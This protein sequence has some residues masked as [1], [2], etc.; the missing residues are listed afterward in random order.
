MTAGFVGATAG[1]VGA[2]VT[3]P[4]PAVV[5]G[6]AAAT[7]GGLGAWRVS[8]SGPAP[9]AAGRT[10]GSHDPGLA[11]E[12]ALARVRENALNERIALLENAARAAATASLTGLSPESPLDRART[13]TPGGRTPNVPNLR[14][15]QGALLTDP[16]TGLFSE[17]YF[18]VA[19][20][21]RIAAARRRLRPV[22]L[23]LLDIVDGATGGDGSHADPAAVTNA[24]RRTLREAD[25]ACRLDD[26]RFALVLEDTPE[27]GA[28]WTVERIRTHLSEG[29]A[30]CTV[31]AGVA[32]YPAHAFDKDE[33][34][35]QARN[36]LAQ[37][38]EWRQDRI[39][40]AQAD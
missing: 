1:V 30:R 34:L 20:E 25:T 6:L 8:S 33:I 39:E 19:L 23:V 18:E 15:G 31:W 29:G 16:A 38:K 7:A 10:S 22:A 26:G 40:V 2:L 4:V 5:A 21:A 35:N 14:A 37:A 12:L 32:C 11:D 28:I 17:A 24:L 3:S 9:S 27:N 13:A 36:A